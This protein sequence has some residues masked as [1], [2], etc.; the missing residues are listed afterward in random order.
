MVAVVEELCSSTRC[1]KCNLEAEE[2]SEGVVALA[3]VVDGDC[4]KERQ[5]DQ[6]EITYTTQS[7][8][9]SF[10]TKQNARI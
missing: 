6:F 5:H 3:V 2:A 7:V 9:A 8:P 4:W 10:H 1:L